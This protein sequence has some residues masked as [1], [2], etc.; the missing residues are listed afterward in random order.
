MFCSRGL[1]KTLQALSCLGILRIE[2]LLEQFPTLHETISPTVLTNLETYTFAPTLI[3]CPASLTFHW[4][5]EIEKYFQS[6]HLFQ[7]ILCNAEFFQTK[8]YI[9]TIKQTVGFHQSNVF[10]ISY[11][12]LRKYSSSLQSIIWEM[13]ILDEA[14]VIRNPSTSIASSVFQL[15]VRYRLA[16][17]GTPIQNQVS[18]YSF[19]ICS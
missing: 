14:H 10:I 19:S 1:G 12:M 2:K 17:S 16:I 8:N 3:V 18:D 13:V 6:S 11:D 15:Q 4:K 9:N 7:P 5:E